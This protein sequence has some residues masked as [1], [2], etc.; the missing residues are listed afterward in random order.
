MTNYT[1]HNSLTRAHNNTA[2]IAKITA[3]IITAT[4]ILAIS[5]KI[6]IPF[7][8]V[9]M[10]L[11]PLVV[12]LIGATLGPSLAAAT[13]AAYLVQGIAGLPVFAA[14]A[15][16][17]YILGPTGGYLVGF[18]VAATVV[19][20]LSARGKTRKLVPAALTM[21]AGIV[22]IYAVGVAQLAVLTDLNTAVT[23]GL[24]PFI[25]GDILKIAI[26]AL[27]AQRFAARLHRRD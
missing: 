27:V 18:L 23:A 16:P 9:P 19:G 3:T 10:T 14:G 2:K 4:L 15:G 13:L 21:L 5:A 25:P 17:A 26:A 22:I 20:H 1:L 8:P 11:Q 12:L 6:Q 7:Y 24:L